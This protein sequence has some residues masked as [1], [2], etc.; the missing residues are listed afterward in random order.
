MHAC[1]VFI[2]RSFI[3][4]IY[5]QCMYILWVLIFINF[6]NV[7]FGSLNNIRVNKYDLYLSTDGYNLKFS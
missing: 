6:S 2:I 7:L 4:F 3:N 5:L 1:L